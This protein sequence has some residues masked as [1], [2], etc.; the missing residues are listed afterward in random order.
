MKIVLENGDTV[1]ISKESYEALQKSVKKEWPQKGDGYYGTD[2][3]GE[4]FKSTWDDDY[5]DKERT[6]MGN[7]FKTE[8]EAEMHKLRLESMAQRWKPEAYKDY[9]YWEF[10]DEEVGV[11]T[12]CADTS[13]IE[14]FFIGNMH[15]TEEAAAEWG[16]KYN[17]AWMILFNK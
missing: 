14:G 3:K 11:S 8:G 10:D 5:W 1:E 17:D 13:E 16:A 6:K 12:W 15:K 4:M 2:T 9:F 7:C